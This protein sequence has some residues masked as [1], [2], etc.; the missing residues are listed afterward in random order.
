MGAALF[1]FHRIYFDHWVFNN[2]DIFGSDFTIRSYFWSM[3]RNGLFTPL[4]PYDSL[5]HTLLM[6]P[7]H[8]IL[9]P[10]N[11]LLLLSE[12]PYRM[13]HWDY[14]LHYGIAASGWYLYFKILI[15]SRATSFLSALFMTFNGVV[16][17]SHYRVEIA[18]YSWVPWTVWSL[19]LSLETGHIRKTLY[20]GLFF[21]LIFLGGNPELCGVTLLL[22]FFSI[23]YFH[24]GSKVW[25]LAFVV[26]GVGVVSGLILFP[27]LERAIQDVPLSMRNYGFEREVAL[28]ASDTPFKI[29]E[30]PGRWMSQ[31][32]MHLT[33]PDESIHSQLQENWYANR[34]IGIFG[35]LCFWF[36]LAHL[37]KDTKGKL[38]F[39][40]CILL[41]CFS[42]AKYNDLAGWCWAHVSFL[43]KFRYP[44]KIFRYF[45]ILSS[46][47]IALGARCLYQTIQ[48]R[49]GRNAVGVVV[50]LAFMNTIQI[51][52]EQ[53]APDVSTLSEKVYLP[54]F[55]P[56]R[57]IESFSKTRIGFCTSFLNRGISLFI[58]GRP[59]GLA[60]ASLGDAT[61]LPGVYGT[62][63]EPQLGRTYY[64]WLGITHLITPHIR[65]LDLLKSKLPML[66]IYDRIAAHRPVR[67]EPG[68]DAVQG[69]DVLHIR[70]ATSPSEAVFSEYW[71]FANLLEKKEFIFDEPRL[72]R[73]GIHFKRL[74]NGYF[75]IQESIYVDEEGVVQP[76]KPKLKEK[77][78]DEYGP[79]SKCQERDLSNKPLTR[80]PIQLATDLSMKIDG[81]A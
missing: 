23:L 5:S 15:R 56:F 69:F 1:Y 52:S 8:K 57:G 36:G 79:I 77:L 19:L 3:I 64:D 51:L 9:Y 65:N 17:G 71:Y 29:F 42:M 18:S 74:L 2:L 44:G 45:L 78:L 10:T 4:Y 58:D 61:E 68:K 33:I 25:R 22:G 46:I 49:W 73:E 28:A 59:H 35:A 7:H 12:D 34:S 47:P 54:V 75:P 31:I 43:Q 48:G 13:A 39:V 53:A 26:A 20:T 6:N 41:W 30:L 14:L 21:S 62:E 81:Q 60:M 50:L 76:L 24:R 32:F 37:L 27:L 16:L 80:F 38:L 66:S 55:T 40:F 67:V 63:C 11:L 70:N 72:F